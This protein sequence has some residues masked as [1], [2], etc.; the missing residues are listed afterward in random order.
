M[1]FI[2]HNSDTPQSIEE[3]QNVSQSELQKVASIEHG[4]YFTQLDEHRYL[5]LPPSE[6]PW[7][8]GAC[9]GGPPS[10]LAAHELVGHQPDRDRR[11]GQIHVDFFGEV[12]LK[13]LTF[14]TT[15]LRPGRRIEL[16]ETRAHGDD[17]RVVI[18]AR[19]W[20]LAIEAE[21]APRVEPTLQVPSDEVS[22]PDSSIA[23]F[24]YGA[25][26]DWAFFEGGFTEPG[27][28]TVWARP[29]LNLID[30]QPMEPLE[31]VLLV[32]DS[33]NGISSELDFKHFLF[34]PTVMEIGLRS[35]PNTTEVGLS[36]RT[37]IDH[38]GIGTTR[39]TLFDREHSFGYLLQTLYVDH[40]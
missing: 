8:P 37:T 18:S 24:P 27:P 34:L 29:R 35:R 20:R 1:T 15:T 40:R 38:E 31:A 9:H 12:P 16:V 2:Q 21:R 19:S 28:A 23:S 39:G 11:I 13:P 10:A 32:A 17:N 14:V 22:Y 7:N 25:S 26:I 6:G 4:S 5:P 3:R 36:A 33:A 30:L